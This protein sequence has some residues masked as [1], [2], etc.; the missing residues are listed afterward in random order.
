MEDQTVI[1]IWFAEHWRESNPKIF[2]YSQ[3]SNV[4][5]VWPKHFSIVWFKPSLGPCVGESPAA[6]Y[7][8]P[9]EFFGDMDY[10]RHN[11]KPEVQI[12]KTLICSYWAAFPQEK[13]IKSLLTLNH[14]R[15]NP[16]WSQNHKAALERVKAIKIK[17]ANFHANW[18]V[19]DGNIEVVFFA[20]PT[21][22]YL[23]IFE[24]TTVAQ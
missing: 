15:G 5:H 3:S 21:A 8:C 22:I 17:V 19:F 20:R 23:L 6:I 4:C 13:R 11:T 1:R 7:F 18:K 9:M 16:P 2:S 12:L 14:S 10:M 24:A